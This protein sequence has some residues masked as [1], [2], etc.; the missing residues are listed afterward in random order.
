MLKEKYGYCIIPKGTILFRGHEDDS[1]SSVMFFA[2]KIKMARQFN[3]RIQIWKTL[4]DIEIV[5]LV[6]EIDSMGRVHSS[7]PS[8][9]NQLFPKEANLQFTD[10]DIKH[11]DIERRNKFIQKLDTEFLLD[12]WFTSIENK[13]EVEI[14][15]FNHNKISNS[16]KLLEITND[17][18]VNYFRDSLKRFQI[19]P[20][21]NFYINSE[22]KLQ[23]KSF[24]EHKKYV[25]VC[26]EDEL[27][28]YDRTILLHLKHDWYDMRL[29]LK[30]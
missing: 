9:F 16:I 12:G 20:P 11:H 21:K 28:R 15:L 10:L 23:S 6:E 24:K 26:I 18:N 22:I 13:K 5:F 4:K 14:C 8:V 19:Y 29:K 3:K 17:Q 7:L 25:N 2:S 1:I 30:I 27:E